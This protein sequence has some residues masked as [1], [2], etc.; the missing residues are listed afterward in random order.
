M[1][2][3]LTTPIVLAWRTAMPVRQAIA[4]R[5]GQPVSD[6]EPNASVL[7]AS[8]FPGQFRADVADPAKLVADTVLKVKGKPDIH[9]T[10]AQIPAAAAPK[11]PPGGAPGFGGGKG[12]GGG[13]FDIVFVFPKSAGLT[14]DDKE[15]EFVTK[16]GKMNIRKKFKLKDM[17]VNGKLEM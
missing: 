5:T 6:T 17:V 13:N 8:G 15:V 11:G 14:V 7:L 1:Q 9:P 12:F 10:E 16:V 2:G 3:N 4:R